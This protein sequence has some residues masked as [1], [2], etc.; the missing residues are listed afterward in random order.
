MSYPSS[1]PVPAKASQWIISYLRSDDAKINS[2]YKGISAQNAVN[3]AEYGLTSL[4]LIDIKT[5]ARAIDYSLMTFSIE[6]PDISCCDIFHKPKYN[7]KKDEW[8][9]H[10]QKCFYRDHDLNT[11]CDDNDIIWQALRRTH[12]VRVESLILDKFAFAYEE[13]SSNQSNAKGIATPCNEHFSYNK[14]ETSDISDNNDFYSRTQPLTPCNKQSFISDVFT[15]RLSVKSMNKSPAKTEPYQH[16]TQHHKQHGTIPSTSLLE[17]QVKSGGKSKMELCQGGKQFET[18]ADYVDLV[19]H[20]EDAISFGISNTQRIKGNGEYP[21]RLAELVHKNNIAKVKIKQERGTNTDDYIDIPRNL[22]ESNM[23]SYLRQMGFT[24]MR[25]ILNGVREVEKTKSLGSCS[26]INQ[27]AEKAMLWILGQREEA[28]E[29][30]KMDTARISSEIIT[31]DDDD[32]KNSLLCKEAMKASLEQIVGKR[33]HISGSSTFFPNSNILKSELVKSNFIA[34]MTYCDD[35]VATKRAII[36]FLE[37]E[38]KCS[39]W[40]GDKIP[41]AYFRYNVVGH[42][43][44]WK[45][46]GRSDG[47]YPICQIKDCKIFLKNLEDESKALEQA[48]YM[49]SEQEEGGLGFHVPK[50]FLK[51]RQDESKALE[52]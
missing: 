39:K 27:D 10:L 24:D 18:E 38:K 52:Q 32:D 46:P 12:L 6:N 48:M 26:C 42:I 43:E 37:L 23:A 16:K 51:S 20:A 3:C 49:L 28:E 45:F 40:F 21:S 47:L 1:Y 44:N 50:I 4:L 41:F 30:R 25:E 9:H 33:S 19:S 31:I 17:L 8:M 35:L 29:A 13:S 22:Y 7:A 5:V 34:L 11:P 15:P 14:K 36:K 2:K